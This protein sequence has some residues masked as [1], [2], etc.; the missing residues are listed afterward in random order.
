KADHLRPLFGFIFDELSE[1]GGRG[2]KHYATK[3]GESALFRGLGE[4]SVDLLV[5]PVDD[6]G[7]GISRRHDTKPSNRFEPWQELA[8]GWQVR[9]GFYSSRSRHCQS[10]HFTGPDVFYRRGY[11]VEH[12]LKLSAQQVGQGRAGT[13]IWHVSHVK[14]CQH[15][16]KFG[17]YVA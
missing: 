10:S 3:I 2:R 7:G 11:G 14:A 1:L 6:F 5:K 15:V 17:G 8:D 12:K 16:E 13:A 9:H 4:H